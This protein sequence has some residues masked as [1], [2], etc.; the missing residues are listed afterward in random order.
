MT[1][2]SLLLK[3]P[4]LRKVTMYKLDDITKSISWVDVSKEVF[5]NAEG[6]TSTDDRQFQH[7]CPSYVELQSHNGIL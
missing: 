4:N 2:R 6:W 3:F 7:L 5:P 1:L